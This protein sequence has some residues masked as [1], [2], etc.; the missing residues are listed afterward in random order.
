MNRLRTGKIPSPLLIKIILR[1]G[2]PKPLLE[3]I[4]FKISCFKNKAVFAHSVKGTNDWDEPLHVH[5][6]VPRADG[7]TDSISNLMLLHEE[8]HYSVH[9]DDLDKTVLEARL[10]ALLSRKL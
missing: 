1:K 10:K 3:R 8:C 6:L 2:N 5:H 9:R 4:P 7:G